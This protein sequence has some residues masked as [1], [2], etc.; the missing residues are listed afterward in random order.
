VAPITQRRGCAL[1]VI[2]YSTR[3]TRGGAQYA[4]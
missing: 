3:I 4:Q 2:M 1:S